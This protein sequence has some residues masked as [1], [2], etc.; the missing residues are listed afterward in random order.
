MEATDEREEGLGAIDVE[1][2]DRER[3]LKNAKARELETTDSHVTI[4]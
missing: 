3:I 4:C 1:G 2:N